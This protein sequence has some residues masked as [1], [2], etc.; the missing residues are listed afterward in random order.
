[1]RK[2]IVAAAKRV[3]DDLSEFAVPEIAD[4]VSCRKNFKAAAKS[5][6]RQTLKKQKNGGGRKKAAESDQKNLQIKLITPE[7]TFSQTLLINHVE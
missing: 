5:V 2:Y 6:R 3:G 4:V 7:E 1:M